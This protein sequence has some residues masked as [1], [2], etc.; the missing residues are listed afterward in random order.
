M[1]PNAPIIVSKKTTYITEPLG[2]DG[3]PDY[4]AYINRQQLSEGVTPENNAAVLIWQAVGPDTG[5]VDTREWSIV[6]D[7]LGFEPNDNQRYLVDPSSDVELGKQLSEW[8]YRQL[9]PEEQIDQVLRE[10]RL[11]WCRVQAASA[12]DAAVLKPWTRDQL[13]PLHEWVV[14]N[15]EPL[16][17][18]T[19]ASK[20]SK[21]Y[22]PSPSHLDGS[23]DGLIETRLPL[24]HKIR[25]CSRALSIRAMWHFGENRPKEAWQ[26]IHAMMR[27]AEFNKS[28]WHLTPYLSGLSIESESLKGSVMLLQCSNN[29]PLLAEEVLEYFKSLPTSPDFV[30][31][32]DQSERLAMIDCVL[33]VT[34][35]RNNALKAVQELST[36]VSFDCNVILRETN[37]V[38]D[39]I[40]AAG[41]SKS[42]K[43]WLRS[44]KAI[45]QELFLRNKQINKKLLFSSLFS[46]NVRNQAIST[47]LL[48]ILLP[49]LDAC[50]SGQDRVSVERKLTLTAAALAVYRARHGSYPENLEAMVPEIL[51]ELPS[52]LYSGKPFIYERKEDDGYLLYSVYENGVDDGGD[53]YSGEIVDGEWV[54]E[55]DVEV[56]GKEADLVIRVPQ[57]KYELPDPTTMESSFRGYG[58]GGR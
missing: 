50:R 23:N 47:F 34:T 42:R 55:E 29:S 10:E 21:Y 40:V 17:L 52:D 22:S 51:P 3:L 39:R 37:D 27:L 14:R 57:P 8:F 28:H 58:G 26:D 15:E 48:G 49:S 4:V 38:F 36:F 53:D 11:G 44:F 5:Y 25:D 9:F 31:I 41:R 30:D 32:I 35:G 13:P 16:R 20:R 54:D 1:G 33:A 43:E 24:T 2:R 12:T 18:I 19:E 6:C 45:D 56:I 46:R 7:S